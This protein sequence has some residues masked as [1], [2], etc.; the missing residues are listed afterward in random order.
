MNSEV[1]QPTFSEMTECIQ[2]VL[3]NIKT[4]NSLDKDNLGYL[5]GNTQQNQI[6]K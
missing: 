2:H 5:D 4:F 1:L 6:E 3:K